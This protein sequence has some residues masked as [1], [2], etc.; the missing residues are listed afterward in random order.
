MAK[1]KTPKSLIPIERIA[2]RIYLIGGRKVMF[3]FR[4]GRA[5]WRTDQSPQSGCDRN[6]A[7]FPDDFMFRLSPEETDALHRSQS[8]TGSQKHRDPRFPPVSS[9][10]KG[11]PMLSGVL[12][13]SALLEVNV[14]IMRA[15]VRLREVLATNEDLARKVAQHGPPDR[16]PVRARSKVAC[17]AAGEEK[18]HRLH[19][20]EGRLALD[21][22]SAILFNETYLRHFF[23]GDWDLAIEAQ[24]QRPSTHS[25]AS[26]RSFRSLDSA[27]SSNAFPTA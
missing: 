23:S 7:R 16:R 26:R 12:R 21:R 5:L 13:S 25:T 17:A 9:R 14:A 1:P 18:S 22:N 24:T 8:V 2:S 20:S 19:S 3:D 10:R 11:V 15:F 6:A 27:G 4:P